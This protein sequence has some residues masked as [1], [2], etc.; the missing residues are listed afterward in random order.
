MNTN[1][2]AYGFG[3][4]LIFTLC[5]FSFHFSSR[6]PSN[7]FCRSQ[8]SIVHIKRVEVLAVHSHDLIFAYNNNNNSKTTS[9]NCQCICTYFVGK[10]RLSLCMQ[11]EPLKHRVLHSFWLSFFAV[12]SSGYIFFVHFSFCT[13]CIYGW[14]Y[15]LCNTQHIDQLRYF[16]INW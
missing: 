1:T 6:P 12:C 9:E 3:K 16:S 4:F 5:G 8:L 10:L 13:L 2:K 11:Y 15:A 7:S 14:E